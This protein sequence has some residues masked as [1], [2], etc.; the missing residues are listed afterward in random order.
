MNTPYPARSQ[1]SGGVLA[2]AIL[3]TIFCCLPFGVV[4]IVYAA[5]GEDETAT[6]WTWAAVLSGVIGIVIALAIRSSG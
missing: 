5:R 2:G 1:T 4:A 3:S 6:K